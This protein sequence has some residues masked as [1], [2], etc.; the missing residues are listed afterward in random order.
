MEARLG[1]SRNASREHILEHGHPN[2]A[3][4]GM[5]GSTSD[6]MLAGFPLINVTGYLPVGYA[7]NEPVQYF[8]TG[9]QWGDK[10]TWIKAKHILKWGLDGTRNQFNQTYFTHSRGTITLHR[11]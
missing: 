5:Q 11:T 8:V 3:S 10:L 2:A 7:A 1:V 4:L 6:P 9:W